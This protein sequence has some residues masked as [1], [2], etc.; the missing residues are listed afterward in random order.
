MPHL[1]HHIAYSPIIISDLL[2]CS[3]HIV[4]RTHG[5][6]NSVSGPWFMTPVRFI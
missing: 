6:V 2:H 1:A 4:Q 3:K 5:I